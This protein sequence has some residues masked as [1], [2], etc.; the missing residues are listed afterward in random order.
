MVS[1]RRPDKVDKIMNI[2]FDDL[3]FIVCAANIAGYLEAKKI[4]YV[5]SDMRLTEFIVN[6]F[7]YWRD[8]EWTDAS[9]QD[10]IRDQ[11]IHE[12]GFEED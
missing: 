1:A 9:F 5:D 12:F 6:K 7:K 4:I 3:Q 11:L 2:E 8:E 10:Y